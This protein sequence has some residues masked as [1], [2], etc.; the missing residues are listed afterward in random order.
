M[1]AT[2][3]CSNFVGFRSS[4]GYNYVV[5]FVQQNSWH[6]DSNGN[7]ERGSLVQQS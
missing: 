7:V 6:L 2:N 5:V 1:T 3:M 4:H